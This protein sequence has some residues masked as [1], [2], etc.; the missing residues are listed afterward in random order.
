I[1]RPLNSAAARGPASSAGGSFGRAADRGTRCSSAG[2]RP[3]KQT[4]PTASDRGSDTD[5]WQP[6]RRTDALPPVSRRVGDLLSP[7]GRSLLEG[8]G[9]GGTSLV[10]PVASNPK[11]KERDKAGVGILGRLHD[12]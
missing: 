5:G 3:R 11:G 6:E 4:D 10:R 8:Q 2:A 9:S 7:S 12:T 1:R